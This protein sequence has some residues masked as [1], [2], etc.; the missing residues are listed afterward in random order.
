[1]HLGIDE[2]VQENADG[3][4]R[5]DDRR[6]R[7]RA[8]R[9]HVPRAVIANGDGAQPVVDDPLPEYQRSAVNALM[10]SDGVVPGGRGRRRAARARSAR[11][12][13]ACGIGQRRRRTARSTRS[14][15][16]GSVVLV[17]GSDLLRADLYTDFL[18]D[19]EAAC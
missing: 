18:T 10:D 7:R 1:M 5:P 16:R 17:E 19:D 8:R 4:L 14:W 11:R 2:L 15:Q 12:R 6:V 13:S 9:S 3:R